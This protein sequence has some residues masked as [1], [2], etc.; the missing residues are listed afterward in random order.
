MGL[1]NLYIIQD[2]GTIIVDTGCQSDKEA[3]LQSQFLSISFFAIIYYKLKL[4]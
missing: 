2:S 4:I 3:K 1:S